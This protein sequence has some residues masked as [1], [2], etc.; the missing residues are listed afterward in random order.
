MPDLG[1]DL[2]AG[3]APVPEV[4]VGDDVVADGEQDA[5]QRLADDERAQV[6]HVQGL[7]QVR[8]AEVHDDALG[9][10]GRRHPVRGVRGLFRERGGDGVVREREVDVARRDGLRGGE[11]RQS[12][13][14][15]GDVAG[16]GQRRLAQDARAGE[17]GLDGGV[18]ELGPGAGDEAR[19]DGAHPEFGQGLAERALD[20]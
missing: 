6:P 7:A 10:G 20:G 11:A 19:G 8:P 18:A 1:D 13:E 5:P 2:P 17:R 3:Q 4:R 12:L 16:D 15:L 9:R 14:P